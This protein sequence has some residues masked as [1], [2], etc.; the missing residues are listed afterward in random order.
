MSG[1]SAGIIAL[2]EETAR[3]RNAASEGA[4]LERFYPRH[5]GFVRLKRFSQ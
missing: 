1:G 5:I 3:R 4:Q 2:P